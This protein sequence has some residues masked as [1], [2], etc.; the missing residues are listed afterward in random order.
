MT[1]YLLGTSGTPRRP[2]VVLVVPPPAVI[3]DSLHKALLT[4]HT[5]ARAFV[6][7]N[8]AS[9]LVLFERNSGTNH[10]GR[11]SVREVG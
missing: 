9:L 4:R 10:S 3:G 7:F 5:L 11:L 2:A 6:L 8:N 1:G